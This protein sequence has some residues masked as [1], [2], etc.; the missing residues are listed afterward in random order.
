MHALTINF[1]T[2]QDIKLAATGAFIVGCVQKST[3]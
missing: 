1:E 3:F 2:T